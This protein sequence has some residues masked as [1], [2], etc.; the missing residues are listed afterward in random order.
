MIIKGNKSYTSGDFEDAANNYNNAL[1]E[2]KN[3]TEGAFNL[4]D[5]LFRQEKYEEAAKQ[6]EGIATKTEN[7]E[8]R[9]WAYHNLGNSLL[10]SK[11]L[12]ESIEAYKNALRANPYNEAARYNLSYAKMLKKQQEQQKEENKDQQDKENQDNKDQQDQQN[13]DQENKDNEEQNKDQKDQEN[14]NK[15][16]QNKDQ[17]NQDKQEGDQKENEQQQPQQQPEQMSQQDAERLLEALQNEEK[18]TQM[19]VKAQKAKGKKVNIDKDW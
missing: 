8:T 5:A 17:Q 15:D 3:S 13:K 19:K 4:G 16:K 14:E 9:S 6:F 2:D 11:K 18:D 10:Q 7:K 12:D 1:N